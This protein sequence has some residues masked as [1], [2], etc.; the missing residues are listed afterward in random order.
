MTG[1]GRNPRSVH[2]GN[3]EGAVALDDKKHH[4]DSLF[5]DGRKLFCCGCL[6]GKII[7]KS[8]FSAYKHT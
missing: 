8:R 7:V 1:P 2:N 5:F 3:E 4:G 6:F